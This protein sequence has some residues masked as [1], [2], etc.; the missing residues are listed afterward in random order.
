MIPTPV[1]ASTPNDNSQAPP[2]PARVVVLA[3]RRFVLVEI[4]LL[5]EVVVEAF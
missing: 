1:G 4:D 3:F 2:C 5:V